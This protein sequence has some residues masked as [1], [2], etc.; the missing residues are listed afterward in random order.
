MLRKMTF[1]SAGRKISEALAIRQGG[2]GGRSDH[3]VGKGHKTRSAGHCARSEGGHCYLA[4]CAYGLKAEGPSWVGAMGGAA[5]APA[6]TQVYAEVNRARLLAARKK[7]PLK[8]VRASHSGRLSL[9][10]QDF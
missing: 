4:L 6:S 8:G 2:R 7:R 9:T 5:R 3:I 10:I 1:R